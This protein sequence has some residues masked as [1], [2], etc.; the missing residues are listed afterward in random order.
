MPKK[1]FSWSPQ[2]FAKAKKWAKSRPHPE[3]KH[4]TL[5]DYVLTEWYESEDKLSIINMYLREE[6]KN[7]K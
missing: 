1:E 2:D 6:L 4:L 5:W 3:V 7:A